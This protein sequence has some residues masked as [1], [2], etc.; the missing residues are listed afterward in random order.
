MPNI[1]F[2]YIAPLLFVGDYPNRYRVR[3]IE[4]EPWADEKRHRLLCNFGDGGYAYILRGLG[5]D[6]GLQIT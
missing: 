2:I 3:P 4:K 6:F 1:L 5:D